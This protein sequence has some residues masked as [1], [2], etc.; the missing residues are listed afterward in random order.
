M[1]RPRQPLPGSL[2]PPAAPYATSPPPKDAEIRARSSLPSLR[3]NW[4]PGQTDRTSGQWRAAAGEGGTTVIALF[5]AFPRSKE[6]S[7]GCRVCVTS[8]LLT[9]S[10]LGSQQ[11]ADFLGGSCLLRDSVKQQPLVCGISS[12]S[13]R[14]TTPHLLSDPHR[15]TW[16]INSSGITWPAC[17]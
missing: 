12:P 14:V 8:P 6:Q 1:S 16:V 5:C 7:L 3:R 9:A 4:A 17:I 13:C 10:V 2:S 15:P 11:N